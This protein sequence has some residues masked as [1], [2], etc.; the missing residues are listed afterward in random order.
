[1]RAL[2]PTALVLCGSGA[3][4]DAVGRLVYAVRQMGSRAPLYEYRGSMPVTGSHSVPS[5]GELPTDAVRHLRAR[6]EAVP[7]RPAAQAVS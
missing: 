5:L 6:V 1:M 7:Q 2:G 4:L 3:T